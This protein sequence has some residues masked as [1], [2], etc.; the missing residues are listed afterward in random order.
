M[1]G[2]TFGYHLWSWEGEGYCYFVV[3][4]GLGCTKQTLANAQGV[5]L[6]QRII[7]PQISIELKW[8]I[9]VLNLDYIIAYC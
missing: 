1:A 2:D 4:R 9:L 5:L 6:K 3:G 8:R 7:Q